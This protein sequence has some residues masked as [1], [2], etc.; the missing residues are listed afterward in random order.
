MG[1]LFQGKGTGIGLSAAGGDTGGINSPYNGAGLYGEGGAGAHGVVGSAVSGGYGGR[2]TGPGGV[3]ATGTG[4]NSAHTAGLNTG[5]AVVGL[6]GTTNGH[7]GYFWGE[8]YGYGV[9]ATGGSAVTGA[10]GIYGKGGPNSGYGVLGVAIA[11]DPTNAGVRGSGPAI[12]VVGAAPVGL[13]GIGTGGNE[14]DVISGNIGVF[15]SGY[16]AGWFRPISGG[17]GVMIRAADGATGT[18]YPVTAAMKIDVQ[19]NT[20]QTAINTNGYIVVGSQIPAST[21]GFANTIT[22]S[23]IPKAWGLITITNNHLAEPETVSVT[24]AGF[25]IAGVELSPDGSTMMVVY[26]SYVQANEHSVLLTGSRQFLGYH[27]VLTTETMDISG[28]YCRGLEYNTSMWNPIN[29][30]NSAAPGAS[31]TR[32]YS[33]ASFAP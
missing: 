8:G 9:Y 10:N 7:G 17:Y 13:K 6:A 18:Y 15:G 31:I 5:T 25:N 26:A 28:F 14:A 11:T 20:G 32:T 27:V 12:G 4:Y 29:F 24:V 3:Y 2:F 19:P 33:F 21:T 1:G 16:H 30:R 23:N 22:R